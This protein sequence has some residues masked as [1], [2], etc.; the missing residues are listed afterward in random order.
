MTGG[1]RCLSINAS[2]RTAKAR[3]NLPTRSHERSSKPLTPRWDNKAALLDMY[4]REANERAS[5]KY[6]LAAL[7]SCALAPLS[8][9][10]VGIAGQLSQIPWLAYCVAGGILSCIVLQLRKAYFAAERRAQACDRKLHEQVCAD[11]LA[12]R[13]GHRPEPLK[14]K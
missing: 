1:E 4:Q 11:E 9:T 2:S 5:S 10:A 3:S 7:V 12:I 8:V 14:D 13:R 6:P